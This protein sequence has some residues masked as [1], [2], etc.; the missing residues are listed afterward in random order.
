[1]PDVN[2]YRKYSRKPTIANFLQVA[3][4]RVDTQ[5]ILTIHQQVIIQYYDN[6][7]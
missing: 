1:M 2:V 6:N 7:N 5:T 4:V 3:W